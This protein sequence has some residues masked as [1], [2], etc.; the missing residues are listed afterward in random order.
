MFC[1]PSPTDDLTDG[2]SPEQPIQLEGIKRAEFAPFL[3]VM[4]ARLVSSNL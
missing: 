3:K 4:M 2:W 1:L